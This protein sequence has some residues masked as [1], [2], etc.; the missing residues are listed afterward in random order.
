MSLVEFRRILNGLARAEKQVDVLNLSGGEPLLHPRILDFIDEALSRQEIVRVSVSTNG[1][2]FLENPNLLEEVK[3]RDIVVSLQFDG[4]AEKVYQV[5]RGRPLLSQKQEI[6]A[7]LH[8]LDLTT[9]L[10]MTAALGV[11]EDQFPA[12]LDYL[13]QNAHV[14]SLMI[15]PLAFTGRGAALS[16]NIKRLTI[17]DITRILGEVGQPAVA[18]EDFVPLPCSH[19]LCF[20]LAFYLM[21]DNGATISLDKLTDASTL[22]DTL[23]NRVIFG[24]DPSEQERLKQMIY[25]LWTGPSGVVPNTE[26]VLAT[27][28]SI[29]KGISVPSPRSRFEARSVFTFMERK[30]KSIFVHAFQDRETFD[31]AR[32]RRCCQAYPQPDGRLVPACAHNVLH[33]W[34]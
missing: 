8:D 32:I 25:D 14:V 33:R 17:P 1:L 13:F 23:S 2:E 9:S 31:I 12:M 21:L 28:R 7:M 34:K 15:Q 11:N 4:F 27:L 10:T 18:T 19:P 26:A 3:V 30:V 29:L 24:L 5:L 6:L 20:S 22:M 16:R